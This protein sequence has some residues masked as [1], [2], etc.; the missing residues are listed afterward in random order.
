[1]KEYYKGRIYPQSVPEFR[2]LQKTD[3]TMEMQIRYRNDNMSY[4][5]K[6][7]SIPNEQERKNDNCN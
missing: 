7:Q 1:M 4:C 5:S 2:Y 6:W 3:G